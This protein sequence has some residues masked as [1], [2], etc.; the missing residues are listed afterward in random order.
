MFPELEE[1]GG[2]DGGSKTGIVVGTEVNGMAMGAEDTG[3]VAAEPGFLCFFEGQ[4]PS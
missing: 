1:V 2:G 4:K 3:T